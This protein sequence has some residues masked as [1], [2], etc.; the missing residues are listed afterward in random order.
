MNDA[1]GAG[2]RRPQHRGLSPGLIQPRNQLE[3]VLRDQQTLGETTGT[4]G[5]L[6]LWGLA[7]AGDAFGASRARRLERHHITADRTS[8]M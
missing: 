2:V 1:P 6:L 4:H 3:G 7:S 8:E 5:H